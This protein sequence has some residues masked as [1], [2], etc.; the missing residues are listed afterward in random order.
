MASNVKPTDM[1]ESI[2]EF[3]RHFFLC[4]EC[5]KEF[6]TMTKNAANEINSYKENVLYLWRGNQ[7]KKKKFHF[8]YSKL[9]FD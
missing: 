9:F 5:V 3:V 2:R 8:N 6:T 4:D 1:I 7:Y